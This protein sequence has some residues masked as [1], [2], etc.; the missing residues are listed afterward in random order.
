MTLARK[1]FTPPPMPWSPKVSKNKHQ[2]AA[3][4]ILQTVTVVA[5]P[6]SAASWRRWQA[7]SGLHAFST[8]LC[9]RPS[10]CWLHLSKPRRLLDGKGACFYSGGSK[11]NL[12]PEQHAAGRRKLLERDGS[13]GEVCIECNTLTLS[14]SLFVDALLMGGAPRTKPRPRR[15]LVDSK[16]L[17]GGAPPPFPRRQLGRSTPV[18]SSRVGNKLTNSTRVC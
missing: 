16:T 8:F 14:T 12:A 1:R 11:R 3:L 4:C 13:L 18:F 6:P 2:P 9:Q 5:V 10:C 7:T 15:H 17:M